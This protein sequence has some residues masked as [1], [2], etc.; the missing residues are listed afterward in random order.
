MLQPIKDV[1]NFTSSKNPSISSFLYSGRLGAFGVCLF[2]FS[3]KVFDAFA[4]N[5]D[6]AVSINLGMRDIENEEITEM[7]FGFLSTAKYPGNFIFE[8]LENEDVD[9]YD[10]IVRFVNKIHKLGGYI[11]I[12]DFG[13]GY[14][15]LLHLASIPYDYIKIDG[16]IVKN[17]CTV[18]ECENLIALISN[19]RK[20]SVRNIKI[21]G[22][23]VENGDIQNKLEKYE[24]DFSQGYLFSVPSPEIPVDDGKEDKDKNE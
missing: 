2:S 16:S 12:D 11:S 23:F 7:I 24:I 1:R 21:V 13:S 17:C 20:L 14:S 10:L 5:P 9:D 18:Q 8:I 19:W 22:E 15:N 3:A 4:D 6:K